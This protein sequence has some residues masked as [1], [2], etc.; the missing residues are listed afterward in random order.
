M[1][2]KIHEMGRNHEELVKDW[3]EKIRTLE[4]DKIRLER[5]CY[6]LL[7]FINEGKSGRR[8]GVSPSLSSHQI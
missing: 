4:D 8:G 3:S 2:G 7:C 5:E 1:N 6:R